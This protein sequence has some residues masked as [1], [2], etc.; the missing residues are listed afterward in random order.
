[1]HAGNPVRVQVDRG[2]RRRIS[3]VAVAHPTGPRS[4]GYV[5]PTAAG[6]RFRWRGGPRAPSGKP[7]RPV[8]AASRQSSRDATPSPCVSAIHNSAVDASQ[9]AHGSP[10]EGIGVAVGSGV[11][12]GI[13]VAVGSGVAVGIGVAVAIGVAVGVG[14]AAGVGVAVEVGVAIAT[15]GSG[16]STE[17]RRMSAAASATTASASRTCGPSLRMGSNSSRPPCPR[18]GARRDARPRSGDLSRSAHRRCPMPS[19]Y[20]RR[21]GSSWA[22]YPPCSS[23][24]VATGAHRLPVLSASCPSRHQA[25]TESSVSRPGI[26]GG[27]G[28][29]VGS[30]ST[31]RPTTV[32]R[33]GI[34]APAPSACSTVGTQ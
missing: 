13:G 5:R 9:S 11:A 8:R 31:P 14:V 4:R 24:L 12:V 23:R 21:P 3:E 10:D 17:L 22:R 16:L 34:A 25:A 19:W 15:A 27:R 30:C 6:G 7:R 1:M 2:G 20:H 32:E 29:R 26:S 18:G 33:V 28:P